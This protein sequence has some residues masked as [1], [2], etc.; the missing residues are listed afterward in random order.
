MREWQPIET[1]PKDG[2]SVDLWVAKLD[3]D[4]KVYEHE[5]IPDALWDVRKL[6]WCVFDAPDGT[7]GNW[8]VVSEGKRSTRATHWMPLPEPPPMS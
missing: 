7:F 4:G 5:R 3:G 1:A 8:P 2:T 6:T